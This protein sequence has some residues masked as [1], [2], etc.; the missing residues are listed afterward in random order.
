M[1]IYENEDDRKLQTR[2]AIAIRDHLHGLPIIGKYIEVIETPQSRHLSHDLEFWMWGKKV[3]VGEI[4]S[5]NRSTDLFR[6]DGWLMDRERIAA[7]NT[8]FESKGFPVMLILQTSDGDI[9][10]TTL[11]NLFKNA[12]KI[13]AGGDGMVKNDHGNKPSNR[14]PRIIPFELLTEAL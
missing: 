14:T 1:T 6:S 7:L 10:Y 5:R 13:I 9:F 12:D 11:A 2:A 3:G 8:Q 4:K